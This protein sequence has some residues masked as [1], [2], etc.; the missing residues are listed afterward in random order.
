MVTVVQKTRYLVVK[1]IPCLFFL[2]LTELAKLSLISILLKGT[3]SYW[4]TH[5]V[6]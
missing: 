6:H 5:G 1:T 4:H 2:S 3:T